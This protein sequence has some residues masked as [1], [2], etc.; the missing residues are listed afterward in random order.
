ME[1]LSS[2][3]LGFDH[4]MRSGPPLFLGLVYLAIVTLP[5]TFLHEWGQCPSGFIN[6]VKRMPCSWTPTA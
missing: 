3:A 1:S 4:F 5:L 6:G 2:I